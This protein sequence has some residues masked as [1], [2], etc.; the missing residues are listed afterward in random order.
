V[1]AL[2]PR[3]RL[4]PLDLVNPDAH[5]DHRAAD[6]TAAPSATRVPKLSI[7]RRSPARSRTC[8][9]EHQHHRRI[10]QEAFH[11]DQLVRHVEAMNP[12]I[13]RG[14]SGWERSTSSAGTIAAA[15]W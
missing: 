6:A 15:R 3:D 12:A 10:I 11:R 1:P 9:E 8:F 2:E 4:D 13:A 7:G 5:G 14:V